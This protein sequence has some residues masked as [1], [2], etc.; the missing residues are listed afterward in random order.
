MEDAGIDGRFKLNGLF[1]KWDRGM[2]WIDLTQDRD[3]W[4]AFENA[5]MNCGFREMWK[6]P[7]PANKRSPFQEGLCS[8]KYVSRNLK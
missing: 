5:T 8:M 6:I 3:G 1:R 2:D 7:G 4:W